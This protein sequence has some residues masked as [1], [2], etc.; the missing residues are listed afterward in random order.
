MAERRPDT[1]VNGP[2]QAAAQ[3]DPAGDH[4]NHQGAPPDAEAL[5]ARLAAASKGTVSAVLLYGSH[6][7]G[8][9]PDR[10]SALD[11]V[12]V[13]EDYRRFYRALR[14]AGELHRP[15]WLLA[16]LSRLL[17]PNVVAFTPED[18]KAGLAKCL[19]VDHDDFERALG[20]APRD[21]FLLARMVQ[22]VA[23]VLVTDEERRQW[24]EAR[25]Q[26]A[27]AGALAWVGPFLDEPFDAEALGRRLLEL[28][29]RAEFRP[30][31]RN[32]ADTIFA[33][34][35]AY[36]REEYAPIL[37]AEADAGSLVRADDGYRFAVP[38]SAAARRRWRLHFLRSKARVTAR[39]LKHVLTFDN[40]LPYI[41]RK[42]ERRTG[43]SVE[44]TSLERRAPLLFL[45]PRVVRVLLHRP[46]R[47]D[48]A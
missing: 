30:E 6:L 15:T 27:R 4:Q 20:P 5:A 40:W 32:R 47:E 3:G 35:R 12:V 36:F 39:W 29:Y 16:G 31:A 44:L 25:L 41:A 11:F 28:C 23:L 37:R 13:V 7:L 46:D 2:T 18:G 8:A 17:P 19:V 24:V 1:S 38:R 26:G 9:A 48:E 21:H 33:K 43:Q 22:R 10:H 34:Q 42:V 14:E 45:W